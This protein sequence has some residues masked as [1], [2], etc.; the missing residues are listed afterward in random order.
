MTK[1]GL[2]AAFALLVLSFLISCNSKG[3][4]ASLI[5]TDLSTELRAPAYPLVTVDPYFNAWSY[6]ENLYDD[7]ARHWT[8]KEFPLVGALRVDGEVYRFMGVEKLPLKPLL[9]TVH[10]ERW[11]AKYT[12]DKPLS[13]GWKELEFNDDAWQPGQA[14]FGTRGEPRLSTLWNT[15]DIWIRRAFTLDEDMDAKDLYLHYSHDDIFEL[16]INGVQ[17]VGTGYSWNYNVQKALS[18]EVKATLKKGENIITA[19]CHN[20]TGGGYVDFGLYEREPDRVSFHRTAEQKSVSVLPTQTIYTFDCGPVELDV[21]FTSPLL[22]DDLTLISRPVSYITYQVK[23]KEGASHDVQVYFEATPQ[24][25]VHDDSQEVD[26]ERV[27][28]D[29]R[30]FLKT[31]TVEQPMLKKSGDAVRIDWGYFYLTSTGNDNAMLNFGGYWDTKEGF[32]ATGELPEAPAGKLSGNIAKEMTVLA[33]SHDLGMV[34][35]DKTAGYIMLGYDDL[36]SIQYFGENLKAY[37]T[38]DGTVDIFEA[39][40][41]AEKGYASIMERCDAFNRSVMEDAERAGGRKY[42]ELAALV[43]RQAVAAHKLVKDKNG[44][45]LFLSKENNSNGSI[46]TVDITYPSSPQF[47][48]YNPELVKGMLNPIFYYSESGK[49]TKPFAAHD[50]GTYPLANGQ[51]YGGDMPIEESGNVLI[52]TAAIAEVEGNAD[53]AASHWEVL[54]TWVDYLVDNGLDPDNQLCTDDFAGHLAHNAN[55]S[56]KAIMGIASYGKLAGMLGKTD[57]S[58][59]YARIAKEMASEWEKMA[60]DGDHYRLTF[61][62]PGTWSQK[63][64]LVWDK[65]LGFNIFDPSIV[66]KEMAYYR[67]KQNEYGLPLDS[68]ATYTKTDWIMWTATLTGEK[69]DFDALVDLVYKYANET[70]SRVPIS[71]WHDTITAKRMNFKARS[72]VGGYFMKMFEQKLFEREK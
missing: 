30:T 63:Y 36:Y 43:Y 29:G 65:L 62:R 12:F 47:L 32:Y 52:L 19:H 4:G 28:K 70:P 5:S 15:S 10:E 66:E 3:S 41:D 60:N 40:N 24:W 25:A 6:T 48:I 67:T 8:D 27:E 58:E 39:F 61:D 34:T 18:E 53:Y 21:I 17:V 51:T 42:A 72:V 55:L 2:P 1:I 23:S 16:Y 71:D 31:G 59:K 38:K 37:W 13:E 45:L 7:H 14:A 33:Y 57:V 54:T 69:D 56:I 68:R 22:V 20:R 50:V 46:G 26:F 35:A 49:W 9:S 64:N 11:E 44:T